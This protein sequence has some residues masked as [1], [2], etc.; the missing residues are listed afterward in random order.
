MRTPN[1]APRFSIAVA[2]LLG[3]GCGEGEAGLAPRTIDGFVERSTKIACVRQD[4]PSEAAGVVEDLVAT[5][6]STFLV[7]YGLDR[8]V[9][10][11]RSDATPLFEVEF[12]ENGPSGVKQ[13]R[14]VALVDDSLLYITDVGRRQIKILDHAGRDRGVLRTDV[15]PSVVRSGPSGVLMAAFPLA[16]GGAVA[17]LVHVLDA[18]AGAFRPLETPVA[19]FHDLR[20]EALAN[21][22][23]LTPLGDGTVIA[24]HQLITS[25]AFVIRPRGSGFTVRETT[26]PV[27]RAASRRLG[28]VPSELFEKEEIDEIATPVLAASHDRASGDYL[29]LTRTGRPG[30]E[31]GTEKAIIRA[32]PDLEYLRSW[33]LDVNAQRFAYLGKSR[34]AIVIDHDAGWH[35]CVLE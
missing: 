23:E 18:D 30:P 4:A 22:I 8:R 34:T 28:K 29:Y 19:P 26:V 27:P 17:R 9:V 20:V 6:D 32:T 24:A 33:I 12:E 7:L 10:H 3:I 35:R 15:P 1:E 31:G 25:R 13:P 14:S 2:L 11:Y 21:L 16:R 5:S